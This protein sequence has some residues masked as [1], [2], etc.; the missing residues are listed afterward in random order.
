M[1]ATADGHPLAQESGRFREP[2]H[3]R[4]THIRVGQSL[5]FSTHPKA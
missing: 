2:L 3:T 5:T 4:E 1:N